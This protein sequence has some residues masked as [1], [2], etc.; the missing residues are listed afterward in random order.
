MATSVPVPIAMPTSAAASAGASLMPSPAIAT[1][2]PFRLEPRTTSALRSGQHLGVDALM[3][4]LRADGL[5]RVAVV[6]GQHH[7]VDALGPKVADRLAARF[8][9]GVGHGQDGVGLAID[10]EED[11]RFAPRSALCPPFPRER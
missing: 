6:A 2:P 11:H 1:T 5:G 7:E 3:P 10:R 9:P 8:L 4:S